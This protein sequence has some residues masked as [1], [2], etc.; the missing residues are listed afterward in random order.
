MSPVQPDI[1]ALLRRYGLRPDKR[2]GQNFLIDSHALERVVEAAEITEQDV[3]LEIG[4]GAGNLTILL[5]SRAREVVAV[6]LDERLIPPLHEVVASY[7]NVQI[8]QGDILALEPSKLMKQPGYKVVANIPYYI[9]S[10]L[11]RQLL[12][13]EP[14]PSSLTL[15]IQ[16][17]V[18][19]RICAEP[20][21]MSVLAL[22]VQVYGE[23]SIVGRIPA[24]SFYPPPKVDS[25]VVKVGIFPSPLIPQQ[26]LNTFFRLVKAGFSQKRKNLRNALAGGMHWST[27]QAE[28]VLC[29]ANID[30]SRRAQ[31]LSLD[32]WAVLSAEADRFMSQATP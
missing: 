26:L 4:A 12:E 6:E 5:A 15:T 30:P 13:A 14:K 8:V 31:T 2:L 27:A 10:A 9:T 28:S 23:P 11:I 21:N 3:V 25:A 32:E 17:E 1:P 16:Q 7:E 22:S 24:G 29:A 20:G 18:A 19:E